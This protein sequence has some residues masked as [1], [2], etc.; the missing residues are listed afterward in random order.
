MTAACT[1][2]PDAEEGASR[3]KD[4]RYCCAK[5]SFRFATSVANLTIFRARFHSPPFL[6][7]A[8][9]VW[10]SCSRLTNHASQSA[11]QNPIFNPLASQAEGLGQ[12]ESSEVCGPCIA[13]NLTPVMPFCQLRSYQDRKDS[14]SPV[15]T[16]N[17]PQ[18]IFLSSS[19]M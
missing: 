4:K 2:L 12:N 6:N 9:P 11:D 5:S 1:V 18:I 16:A 7:T 3:S 8:V 10:S 14:S 15:S 17:T 19:V 13:L